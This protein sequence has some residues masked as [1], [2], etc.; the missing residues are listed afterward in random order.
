MNR[1]ALCNNPAVNTKVNRYRTK[2]QKI[3]G[4]RSG[5]S[6]LWLT[7]VIVLLLSLM[8][9]LTVNLRASNELNEESK[10]HQVLSDQVKRLQEENKKLQEEIQKLKTDPV[11]IEREARKLGM[12][13][14]NEK[15][16]VSA[17]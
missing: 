5:E 15:V 11:A 13:L 12:S 14:P 16:L 6:S 3:R 10:R 1:V 17:N 8:V 4:R 2:A 7:F 9:C